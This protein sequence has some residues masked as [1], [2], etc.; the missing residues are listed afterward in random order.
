[1]HRQVWLFAAVA[2]LIGAGAC[3]QSGPVFDDG[4]QRDLAEAGA[5]GFEMA[6]TSI[7]TEQSQA[8]A[9]ETRPTRSASSAPAPARQQ[10]VYKTEAEI[11]RDMA[12]IRP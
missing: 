4:L 6:P 2:A 5:A 8:P 1:M 12:W 9:A 10:R 11:L 7:A 3:S